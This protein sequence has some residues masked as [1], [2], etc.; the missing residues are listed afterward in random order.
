MAI[1]GPIPEYLSGRAMAAPSDCYPGGTQLV[2]W[3][4][5]LRN[6]SLEFTSYD[7]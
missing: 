5:H 3:V 1:A 7:R 2:E 4:E 6:P